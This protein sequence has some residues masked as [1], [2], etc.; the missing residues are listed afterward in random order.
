[1]NSFLAFLGKITITIPT[2][3]IVWLVSFFGFDQ[4]F[5]ASS[6]ISIVGGALVY[7]LMSIYLKSKMLKKHRLS[8]KEYRYIMKNLEEAKPKI[9]RLNKALMSIKHIPSIK[10]RLEFVRVTRKMYSLSKKE[11]KRFY[12][13]ERFF[14]SNLDSAVELAE[15]YVFLANQPKRTK[16]LELSLYDTRRTLEDLQKSI[17]KD[18]Y[19]VIS[20]DIDQLNFEINVAK[21][22]IKRDDE[23]SKFHDESRRLK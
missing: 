11:P 18:L 14:F 5:A 10:Q 6:A 13:A 8:K 20:D 22:S 15:K 9:H 2:T 16:E 23:D 17:E 4:T 3:I 19:H 1:M 21:Q 12:K 7:W